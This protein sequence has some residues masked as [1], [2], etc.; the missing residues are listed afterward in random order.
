MTKN[1]ITRKWIAVVVIWGGA[2]VLTYL[3]SQTIQQIKTKQTI[4]ESM[5]MD[6]AFLKNNFEKIT[7]VLN[8]RTALYKKID[9]LQIELVALE[10]MLR[11]RAQEQGL[12]NL[13][14]E[15]EPT[16]T[17]SD[18]VSVKISVN[19]TYRQMTLWLKMLESEVPYLVV[20]RVEMQTDQEVKKHIFRIAFDFRYKLDSEDKEAA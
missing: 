17:Q 7:H 5:H 9:S 8:Q 10:N 13:N 19:G 11:K 2:L 15:G 16:R 4:V 18:Q 3:N 1:R 14:M 6:S 20:A 12:S